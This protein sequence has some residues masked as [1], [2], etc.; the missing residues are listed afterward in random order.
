MLQLA[1]VQLSERAQYSKHREPCSGIISSSYALLNGSSVR[2][3]A[4]FKKR[5]EDLNIEIGLAMR[6][7]RNQLFISDV[8]TK[9]LQN[10]MASA[11]RF[12]IEVKTE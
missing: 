2:Y 4:K 3:P 8:I 10:N 7:V 9:D 12:V 11:F 6:F 1:I 5:W